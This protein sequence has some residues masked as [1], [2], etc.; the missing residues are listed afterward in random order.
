MRRLLR[1]SLAS[2][3]V[4]LTAAFV[5]MRPAFLNRIRSTASII[6]SILLLKLVHTWPSVCHIR[7]PPAL[8][9]CDRRCK[10]YSILCVH[11][12]RPMPCLNSISGKSQRN[13]GLGHWSTALSKWRM[14]W[15]GLH[16]ARVLR[17]E[18]G[19]DQ[20]TNMGAI[21]D[22]WNENRTSCKKQ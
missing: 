2:R 11:I 14:L 17:M 12:A 6:W 16:V 5:S 21:T 22:L 10:I 20:K 4:R 18:S 19:S 8:L 9:T 3:L 1:L 15:L 7:S 13:D